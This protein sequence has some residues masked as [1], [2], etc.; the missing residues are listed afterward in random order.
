[1]SL[2]FDHRKQDEEAAALN[3]EKEGGSQKAKIINDGGE[4]KMKRVVGGSPA[5][6]DN[7]AKVN[8]E[9]APSIESPVDGA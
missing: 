3:G 6:N 8:T 1:M 2:S 7:V 9:F 4:E 5:E